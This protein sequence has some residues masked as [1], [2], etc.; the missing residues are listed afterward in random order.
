MHYAK[1][2]D[3]IPTIAA[4]ILQRAILLPN[5][6][7]KES[8]EKKKKKK[9][10]TFTSSKKHNTPSGKQKQQRAHLLPVD[11]KPGGQRSALV[12]AGPE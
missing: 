11:V 1:A 3:H 2:R 12:A 7:K 10:E 6:E 8:E 9:K 4:T 5:K